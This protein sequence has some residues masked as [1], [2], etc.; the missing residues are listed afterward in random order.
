MFLRSNRRR[1]NGKLHR[2]WSVVENRRLRD[3]RVAQRQVMYLGEINDSQEL[4]WRKTLSVFD[5]DVGEERQLELFPD[6]RVIPSDTINAISLRMLEFKL[7]RPRSLGDCWLGCVLWDELQMDWFWES[8]LGCERGAVWWTKVLQVLVIN[9][10]IDPASEF[11]VHRQWFLRSAMDELLGVDFEVASKDRLY[12][13][14]DRLLPHKDSLFQHLVERWKSLFNASFDVLLY[15]LT[16]TYFEGGCENIPKAKH[17]YSRDGRPDCRQVVIAVVVTTEGLPLAY[18]VLAGNTSD[19][20]TLGTFLTKIES[21]Y[22]KA[23]RVWVMDRG[24]PTK[25]SLQRMREEKIA[26]VVGTPRALLSKLQEQLIEK[27]WE[28]VH[29]GMKVRLLDQD[30]ELYVQAQSDDRKNKENAMRRRK[31]RALVHGLNRLKR[32]IDKGRITRDTL[33]G[34]VAVLKKQA[35]KVASFITVTL[36][37][38][39]DELNRK[40][41]V[42]QF[43]RNKWR[44]AIEKDGSYILRAFIPARRDDFPEEMEKKAPVLWEWYMQLVRVEDAFRILKSDL[45]LRPIHHQ[46]EHRVEAHIFIAFLGYCLLSHLKMKLTTHAPGL[47]APAALKHLARIQM[48]DVEIP[49]TDGRVLVLSRYTEPEK[50]QLMVLEKLRLVLPAQPPPKLR[51]GQIKTASATTEAAAVTSG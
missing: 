4:A 36:P 10:L 49:T 12:R 50:E 5:Q 45:N 15:D 7:H 23:R 3:G 8:P 20:T 35:G 19:K 11:A 26:Y 44:K 47:T 24:I 48:V 30:G 16:S 41:F 33:I 37:K 51:S 13:C 39:D 27:S 29:E 31:L 42:C 43:D 9:R 25:S 17:G 38:A 40:T 18:E 1:K 14:L 21:M 46:L 6:D 32:A 28:P 22:G 2:Y 34:K